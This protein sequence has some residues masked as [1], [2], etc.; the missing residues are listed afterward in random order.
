MGR[1]RKR[2]R[3]VLDLVGLSHSQAGEWIILMSM[4]ILTSDKIIMYVMTDD[5]ME[6]AILDIISLIGPIM[7][8]HY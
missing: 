1:E 3:E 8:L 7:P 5:L 6:S 4:R 2:E